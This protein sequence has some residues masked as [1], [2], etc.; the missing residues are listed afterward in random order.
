LGGRGL[1]VLV[2]GLGGDSVE[3]EE[4]VATEL[5][6][7]EASSQSINQK[8]FIRMWSISAS[9]KVNPRVSYINS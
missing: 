6:I 7:R 5:R 3:I 1:A 9:H 2:N 8:R 4:L